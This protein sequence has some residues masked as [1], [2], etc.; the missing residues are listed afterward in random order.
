MGEM[1]LFMV[2]FVVAIIATKCIQGLLSLELNRT[3]VYL[4]SRFDFRFMKSVCC[5]VSSKVAEI[6]VNQVKL[7]TD[8]V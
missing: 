1:P 2:D 7:L 8:Q 3:Q 6:K 4:E 5:L